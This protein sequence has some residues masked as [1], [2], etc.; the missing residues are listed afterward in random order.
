MLWARKNRVSSAA[1]DQTSTPGISVSRNSAPQAVGAP[2]RSVSG[3]AVSTD[4]VTETSRLITDATVAVSN[5]AK[6]GS[7]ETTI[8]KLK[9]INQKLAGLKS[10]WNALPESA[11]VSGQQVLTPMVSKL[12]SAVQPVAAL[13]AVG[14]SLRPHI[15][16]LMKNL[17]SFTGQPPAKVSTF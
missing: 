9:E 3:V 14:D 17:R 5:L 6:G 11:R 1:V 16:E 12:E 10:T 15:D 2:S 7:A 13:P 8:P 4:I